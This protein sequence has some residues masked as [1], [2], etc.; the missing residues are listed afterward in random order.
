MAV[1]TLLIIEL[2]GW[3]PEKSGQALF[4]FTGGTATFYGCG[5]SPVAK[6][7]PRPTGRAILQILYQIVETA[8]INHPLAACDTIYISY[9]KLAYE[10]KSRE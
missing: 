4:R 3:L 9:R 6:S 2:W 8:L 5:I 1:G 10:L 7:W